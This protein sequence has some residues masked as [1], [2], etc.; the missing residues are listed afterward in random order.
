MA[1]PSVTARNGCDELPEGLGSR[2][3]RLKVAKRALEVR[4]REKAVVERGAPGQTKPKEGSVQLTD[5]QSPIMPGGD[6]IISRLQRVYGRDL[7]HGV[8]R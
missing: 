4:A 6:G 8:E 1:N 7:S 3:T 2:E 5:P